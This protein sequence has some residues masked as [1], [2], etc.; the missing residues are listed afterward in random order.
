MIKRKVEDGV[1]LEMDQFIRDTRKG[2]EGGVLKI[3]SG[4]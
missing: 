3:G 1:C 2:E 4:Y